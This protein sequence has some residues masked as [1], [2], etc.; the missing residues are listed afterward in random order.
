MNFEGLHRP[1]RRRKYKNFYNIH[2]RGLGI[3]VKDK[4]L[5]KKCLEVINSVFTEAQQLDS[6]DTDFDDDEEELQEVYERLLGI[7][8]RTVAEKVYNGPPPPD[9]ALDLNHLGEPVHHV[10][11]TRRICNKQYTMDGLENTA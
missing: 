11:Q 5:S 3:S 8:V 10:V 7:Y 1:L 6:D 2:R 9:L 4:K